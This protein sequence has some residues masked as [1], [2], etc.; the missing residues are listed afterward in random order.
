MNTNTDSGWLGAPPEEIAKS[1]T[2]YQRSIDFLNNKNLALKY[3]GKWVAVYLGKMKAVEDD[4]D[5][6]LKVL[7]DQ[8]VPRAE[9]AIEFFEKE[10]RI[11]IL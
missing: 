8:N 1:L 7:D 11:L 2:K 6:L 3:A 10:K 5:V 4:L 9:T